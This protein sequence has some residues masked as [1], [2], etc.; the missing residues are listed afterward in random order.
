M[1]YEQYAIDKLRNYR[2]KAA[3]VQ[4]LRER[5]IAL[6]E[7][8]RAIK[9]SHCDAVSVDGA[10]TSK[11]QDAMINLIA[12]SDEQRKRYSAN[13]RE[14]QQIER[15]LA[16]LSEDERAVLDAFYIAPV[17]NPIAYLKQTRFY[18][19]TRFYE[20]RQCA[21]RKF[22]KAYYGAVDT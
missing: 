11:A 21:V 20:I 16:V 13:K 9:T 14:V 3:S 2:S 19:K 12:D 10:S 17:N 15:A 4:N 7:R 5:I 6:E 8:K 1:N 22:A 18:E